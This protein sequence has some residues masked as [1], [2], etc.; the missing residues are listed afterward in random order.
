MIT[1]LQLSS[2]VFCFVL[3]SYYI[4]FYF[5]NLWL[6][7]NIFFPSLFSSNVVSRALRVSPWLLLFLLQSTLKNF[8]LLPLFFPIPSILPYQSNFMKITFWFASNKFLPRLKQW[9]LPSSWTI[10][11]TLPNISPQ[12]MRSVTYSIQILRSMNNKTSCLLHGFWL[13]WPLLYSLTWLASTAFQI[14]NKLR[15]Y[16]ATRNKAKIKNQELNWIKNVVTRG[17]S[18]YNFRWTSQ[19]RFLEH[20]LDLRKLPGTTQRPLSMSLAINC[21]D[22]M[23]KA[24]VNLQKKLLKGE[25]G[26]PADRPKHA[27]RKRDLKNRT[28]KDTVIIVYRRGPTLLSPLISIQVQLAPTVGPSNHYSQT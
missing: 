12:K 22:Q 20:S 15:L 10:K 5:W 13:P 18:S 8:L 19:T 9:N 26:T 24:Q 7:M 23:A 17:T 6:W 28:A 14:W 27:K 2:F 21:L 16:F 25:K 4:S 11:I 3:Y 1:L